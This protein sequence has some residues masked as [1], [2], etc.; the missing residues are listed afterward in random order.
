[1]VWR[2]L[3]KL[4]NLIFVIRRHLLPLT[5][6][7]TMGSTR[8]QPIVVF[9]A[10]RCNYHLLTKIGAIFVGEKFPHLKSK[11]IIATTTF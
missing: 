6:K 4:S 11:I 2:L 7:T 5:L 3:S 10:E 8:V 1:M 9:R